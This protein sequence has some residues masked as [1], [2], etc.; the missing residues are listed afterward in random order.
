M[1]KAGHR[2]SNSVCCDPR[3]EAELFGLMDREEQ[4]PREERKERN[5]EGLFLRHKNRVGCEDED[6]ESHSTTG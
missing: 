3:E 4:R 2:G 5:T 6:Q 1:K